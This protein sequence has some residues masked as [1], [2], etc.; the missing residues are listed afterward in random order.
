M[1]FARLSHIVTFADG[2]SASRCLI[3]LSR[4]WRHPAFQDNPR[5]SHELNRK[6][7]I[8]ACTTLPQLWSFFDELWNLLTQL[9]QCPTRVGLSPRCDTAVPTH[10]FR[11]GLGGFAVVSTAYLASPGSTSLGCPAR[12]PVGLR[13]RCL[14]P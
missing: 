5:A 10:G 6:F 12:R 1:V 14:P 11:Q 4:N 7:R 2:R 9:L 8:F 13:C 3:C